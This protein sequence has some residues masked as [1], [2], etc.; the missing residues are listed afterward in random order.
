MIIFVEQCR[1]VQLSHVKSEDGVVTDDG[2]KKGE[3][4]QFCVGQR[5]VFALSIVYKIPFSCHT[6]VDLETLDEDGK[7]K[8]IIQKRKVGCL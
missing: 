2:K 3:E 6:L 8:H 7:R 5:P 4:L 1:D